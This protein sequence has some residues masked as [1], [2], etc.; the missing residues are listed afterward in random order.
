MIERIGEIFWF[1]PFYYLTWKTILNESFIYGRDAFPT[2]HILSNI[3]IISSINPKCINS[4]SGGVV[5]LADIFQFF[6]VRF[7][8]VILGSALGHP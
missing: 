4:H 7:H 8:L 5:D 3:Y 1:L 2:T 6:S